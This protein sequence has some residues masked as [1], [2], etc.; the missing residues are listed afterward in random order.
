MSIENLITSYTNQLTIMKKNRA[1]T[2]DTNTDA[3]NECIDNQIKTVA[4][5]VTEL[6]K[7]TFKPQIDPWT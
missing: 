7:L 5:F 6:N 3:A 4:K 1:D 2:V